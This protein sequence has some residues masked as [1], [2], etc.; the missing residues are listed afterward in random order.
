MSTLPRLLKTGEVLS[1][2]DPAETIV[3]LRAEVA[4]LRA[5]LDEMRDLA[6]A[7]RQ[8]RRQSDMAV[9]SVRR[10]LQPLAQPSSASWISS[11]PS[12]SMPSSAPP[13]SLASR[14]AVPWF[15]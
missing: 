7:L 10:Q 4:N 1:P 11:A 12:L 15:W 9:G 8:E 3:R 14:L 2:D 6:E 5:Q 13:S